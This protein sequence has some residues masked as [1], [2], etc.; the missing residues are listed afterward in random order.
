MSDAVVHNLI[1]CPAP[2]RLDV[3]LKPTH[4]P[5]G[6]VE[7]PFLYLYHLTRPFLGLDL[8]VSEQCLGDG[9]IARLQAL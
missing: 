4:A 9:A 8:M 2:L 5:Q 3:I 7:T 1:P 6:G